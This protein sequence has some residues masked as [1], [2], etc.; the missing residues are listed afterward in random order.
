MSRAT[1]AP[2]MGSRLRWGLLAAFLAWAAYLAV[3]PPSRSNWL[4]GN[5]P[6]AV[7]LA[8]VL[9]TFRIPL[10]DISYVLA[11]AFLGL[12]EYGTHYGYQ[13]PF[14]EGDRNHYDR[15]IHASFG[16]LLVL[17]LRDLL[18]RTGRAAGAWASFLAVALLFAAGGLYEVVEWVGAVLLYDGPPEWFLG[19]QGDPLD[20]T[21]DMALSLAASTYV[22]LLAAAARAGM[23]PPAGQPRSP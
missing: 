6:T 3:D 13:V 4:F 21:K 7:G 16:A 8:A 10:A 12:H 11:F 9:W 18:A 23:P 14:M 17:P 5:I 1:V 2:G 15:L 19:H 20:A 22:V